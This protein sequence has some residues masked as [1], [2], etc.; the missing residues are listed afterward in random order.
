M[1]TLLHSFRHEGTLGARLTTLRAH[2][3]IKTFIHSFR[4]TLDFDSGDVGSTNHTQLKLYEGTHLPCPEW[5]CGVI[6]RQTF[7]TGIFETEFS[8][9]HFWIRTRNECSA[10]SDP[11]I[12]KLLDFWTRY[13]CEAV[14]SKL[15]KSPCP[16]A[17]PFW[18][19][20][21]MSFVQRCLASV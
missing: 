9:C 15:I 12:H 11:A 20:L 13:L 7:T 14:F 6:K 2:R 5:V 16:K 1:L 18:K 8:L 19:M 10:I 17:D 3:V 21:R 4:N